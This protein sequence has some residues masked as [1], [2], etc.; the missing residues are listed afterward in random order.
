[1]KRSIIIG[2]IQKLGGRLIM[3]PIFD[4]GVGQ[5]PGLGSIWFDYPLKEGL[6]LLLVLLS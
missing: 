5:L 3:Q 4:P 6:D 1:M 2:K